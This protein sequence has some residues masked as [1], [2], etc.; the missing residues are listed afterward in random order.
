MYCTGINERERF[1]F[2][3]VV[4]KPLRKRLIS[5]IHDGIFSPHQ[6]IAQTCKKI[7]QVAWWPRWRADVIR[8]I[9]NCDKC[10]RIKNQKTILPLSRPLLDLGVT[11]EL[12]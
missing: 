7:S 10:Q 2:R 1:N 6:G 9:M 8:Y 4:P 3:L 12:M 5:E 11:L